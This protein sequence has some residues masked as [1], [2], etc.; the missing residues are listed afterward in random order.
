MGHDAA[1]SMGCGGVHGPRGGAQL[2]GAL[3][4]GV[5]E[6]GVEGRAVRIAQ[7]REHLVEKDE[8]RVAGD[9]G[10]VEVEA[11]TAVVAAAVRGTARAHLLP[12]ARQDGHAGQRGPAV[13]RHPAQH[14]GVRLDDRVRRGPP[15]LQRAVD[16]PEPEADVEH[17]PPRRGAQRGGVRLHE[18]LLPRHHHRP[19]MRVH[20]PARLEAHALPQKGRVRAAKRAAIVAVAVLPAAAAGIAPAAARVVAAAAAAAA[21]ASAASPTAS[22]APIGA[23][24]ATAATAAASSA[25]TRGPVSRGG[26]AG[27][28]GGGSGGGLV[29][30]AQHA[31]AACLEQ[32]L[33]QRA[34]PVAKGIRSRRVATLVDGIPRRA[35]IQ[36]LE[37][38][39]GAALAC[40]G[41]Q[42]A[43]HLLVL[44]HVHAREHQ[45]AQL[46]RVGWS[47]AGG[48][49]KGCE[50]LSRRRAGGE[51]LSHVLVDVSEA[52]LVVF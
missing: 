25:G 46:G 47:L 12:R 3:G 39:L 4:E 17:A 8:G 44:H 40:S 48:H 2:V 16:Q 49:A 10:R 52:S 26:A 35:R 50:D 51:L 22:A 37:R 36:Q 28:G 7:R 27:R 11:R 18:R 31:I 6:D 15:P 34:V 1:G 33:E 24:A 42:R 19:A 43:W 14:V 45:A 9:E 29:D 32:S 13:V 21:A 5:E 20:Q 23:P 30:L 38:I 41:D